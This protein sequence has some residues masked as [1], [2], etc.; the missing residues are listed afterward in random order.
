MQILQQ[1][2]NHWKLRIESEDDLWVLARLASKGR[3]LAMLGER[4][5]ST[6]AESGS[7]AKAA[8]R[9]KMW[10]QLNVLNTEYKTY[11]DILRVHGTI[12]QAPI[13]IGSHHT[14]L[15]ETGDEIELESASPFPDFDI[16]LLNDAVDSSNKS[17]VSLIVVENDE[18]I[19]FEITSRGLREGATWTMRG[20]GKRVMFET[21]RLFLNPFRSKFAKRFLQRRMRRY[22]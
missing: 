15:I 2:E 6:T 21:A 3:M 22:Q 5:D 7:R 14:H 9:K 8:E 17:N 11:S 1:G 12:E 20:G 19:L 10:I 18:I 13:D 16:E 4:R